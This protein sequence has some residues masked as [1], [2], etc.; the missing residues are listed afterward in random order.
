MSL[1]CLWLTSH[2]FLVS[3]ALA[4]VALLKHPLLLVPENSSALGGPGP[5]AEGQARART[6]LPTRSFQAG[7]VE[8]GG[9]QARAAW[10]CLCSLPHTWGCHTG[11]RV[12]TVPINPRCPGAGA[13]SVTH[14]APAWHARGLPATAEPSQLLHPGTAF[15]PGWRIRAARGQRCF[16]VNEQRSA[17][18]CTVKIQMRSRPTPATRKPCFLL[19]KKNLEVI[20]ELCLQVMSPAAPIYHPGDSFTL[21][22]ERSQSPL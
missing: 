2:P 1:S 19:I 9:G 20:P 15:L 13:Q 5:H 4:T 17:P 12:G 3:S 18:P 11:M 8:E 14:T 6:G 22:S 7:H 16:P 21:R 10:D